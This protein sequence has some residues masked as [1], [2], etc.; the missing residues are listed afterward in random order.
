MVS[1]GP[2]IQAVDKGD[3]E[4]LRPVMSKGIVYVR[5]RCDGSLMELLGVAR[6]P[7]LVRHSRLALLIMLEAHCEDHRSSASNVLARSRQRAWIIRGRFLAK[8]VCKSCPLCKL[9]RRKM[10]QQLMADIP[11]HQLYPCLPFSYVSLDF[12][13]PYMAKD[14]GNSRT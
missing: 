9:N 3:L 11:A 4:P 10:T 2:T 12:A 1:M 14:M 13:G 7:V 5:G 6:L 8:L